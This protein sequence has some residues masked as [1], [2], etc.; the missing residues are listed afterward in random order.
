MRAGR[1]RRISVIER[2]AALPRTWERAKPVMAWMRV[3]PAG[4]Q[5]DPDE[6]LPLALAD[7]V[8]EQELGRAGQDEAGEAADEEQAEAQG[9]AAL[10]G[11][12]ELGGVR[13]G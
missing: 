13:G 11:V 6:Q 5:D 7:D 10:A 2:C 1:L 4:G 8:V 3:A 9:E 12:D